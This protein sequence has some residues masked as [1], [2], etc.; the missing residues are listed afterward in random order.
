MC[1]PAASSHERPERVFTAPAVMPNVADPRDRVVYW[2]EHDT[3]DRAE[4]HYLVRYFDNGAE[5]ACELRDE[6]D[7]GAETAS[8]WFDPD[9]DRE[10]VTGSPVVY[11]TPR[12]VLTLGYEGPLTQWS[13]GAAGWPVAGGT[14]TDLSPWEY[15]APPDPVVRNTRGGDT[16]VLVDPAT[17]TIVWGNKC[18]SERVMNGDPCDVGEWG[19]VNITDLLAPTPAVLGTTSVGLESWVSMAPV[20]LSHDAGAATA[21]FLFALGTEISVTEEGGVHREPVCDG[22]ITPL[23]PDF[24]CA[25]STFLWD[26]SELM[27]A[28]RWDAEREHLESGGSESE[29]PEVSATSCCII[30]PVVADAPPTLANGWVGEP[31]PILDGTVLFAAK[32][33]GEIYRFNVDPVSGGLALHNKVRFAPASDDDSNPMLPPRYRIPPEQSPVI[34]R[35]PADP[36]NFE[37]LLMVN[38]SV[39]NRSKYLIMDVDD[40]TVGSAMADPAPWLEL[41]TEHRIAGWAPGAAARSVN[42]QGPV[43]D[44]LTFVVAVGADV[45]ES[46]PATSTDCPWPSTLGAPPRLYFVSKT[47]GSVSTWSVTHV[48]LVEDDTTTGRRCYE[49]NTV[50]VLDASGEPVVD[51]LTGLAAFDVVYDPID[52]T[53]G[54]AV[55]GSMVYVSTSDG[56]FWEYDT[57]HPEAVIHLA[58]YSGPWPRFRRNN[59]GLAQP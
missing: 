15:P 1:D 30:P 29:I 35:Y 49:M 28:D 51:P 50:P 47:G 57:S 56:R 33:H 22:T 24:D 10:G 55:Q 41:Q 39:E 18:T 37:L 4:N 20:G 43:Y 16:S 3:L 9:E 6:A 53:A 8:T 12:R 5:R 13:V 21:D 48:D 42:D 19:R 58:G 52:V 44:G 59:H 11:G 31:V 27:M 14:V 26:G 36:S 46:V 2:V 17:Q 32:A 23:N 54:V 40:W 38:D 25:L 34:G 45:D 7:L